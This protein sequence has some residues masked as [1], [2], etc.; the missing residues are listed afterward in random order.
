MP[1]RTTLLVHFRRLSGMFEKSFREGPDGTMEGKYA[2][3]HPVFIH[4]G[5]AFYLAGCLAFLEG[6]DGSFSWNKPGQS[7][8]DFD[9]FVAGNPPQSRKSYNSRGISKANMNALVEIRNAVTHN[10]GDL[11]LNRN[12]NSVAMV[13][14]AKL[15]GVTLTGTVVSLG[16]EFLEFVRVAALAVRN[17]HGES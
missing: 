8:L 9:A 15:P 7:I 17:Y 13:T 11:S 12:S 14:A 1:D 6:E 10:G 4:Y 2:A 5:Y 16:F 3:E